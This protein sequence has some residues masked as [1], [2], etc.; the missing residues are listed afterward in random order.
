MITEI[1]ESDPFTEKKQGLVDTVDT[2]YP[3]VKGDVILFTRGSQ[4][5]RY[6]VIGVQV[7]IGDAGLRREILALKI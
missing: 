3:W 6:R 1:W 7:E 5:L 4:R 2:A